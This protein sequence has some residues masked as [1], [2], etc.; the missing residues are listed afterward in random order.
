M[1]KIIYISGK[2]TGDSGYKAKFKAVAD[3]YEAQGHTVFNPAVLPFSEAISWGS[4]MRIALEMLR[5]CDTIVMLPDWQESKG[6]RIELG[7]A[8]EKGLEVIYEDSN[9]I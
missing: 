8:L 9:T 1:A 4:Y 6:A 5:I 3:K 7:F 2:I